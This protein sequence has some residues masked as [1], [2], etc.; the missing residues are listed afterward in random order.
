MCAPAGVRERAIESVPDCIN[1][2]ALSCMRE[3]AYTRMRA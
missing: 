2:R 1:E 3:C